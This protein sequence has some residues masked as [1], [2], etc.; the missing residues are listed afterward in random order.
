MLNMALSNSKMDNISS[1]FAELNIH[2][3]QS[4]QRT[5][6]GPGFQVYRETE[7]LDSEEDY[8]D[9]D[10]DQ[11]GVSGDKAYDGEDAGQGGDSHGDYE[12]N[13]HGC[14][15]EGEEVAYDGDQYMLDKEDDEIFYEEDEDMMYEDDQDFCDG[16]YEEDQYDRNDDK[17]QQEHGQPPQP[18][19]LPD[20]NSATCREAMQFPNVAIQAI[21]EMRVSYQTF[22]PEQSSSTMGS[23]PNPSSRRMEFSIRSTFPW[24]PN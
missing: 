20:S 19:N 23:M 11:H 8:E 7:E 22:Y 6:R 3:Q 17:E 18:H 2:P 5:Q 15:E 24:R 14:Y 4:V 21:V 12:G 1:Q 10:D 16:S 9:Y 13:Y